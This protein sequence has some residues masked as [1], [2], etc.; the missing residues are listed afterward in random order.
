MILLLFEAGEQFENSVTSG[1]LGRQGSVALCCLQ[2]KIT[3]FSQDTRIY[4]PVTSLHSSR[5]TLLPTSGLSNVGRIH[6]SAID[7]DTHAAVRRALSVHT[8]SC[9]WTRPE[10]EQQD[11][12][13]PSFVGAGPRLRRPVWPAVA[14]LGRLHHLRQL[15]GPEHPRLDPSASA[16]RPAL[17]RRALQHVRPE[18]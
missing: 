11:A 2:S 16:V 1:L 4:T 8:S 3:T 18:P 17:C 7:K 12:M 13:Q 5:E 15:P 10:I 14:S 6:P 9:S